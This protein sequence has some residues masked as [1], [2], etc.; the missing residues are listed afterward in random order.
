MERQGRKSFRTKFGLFH[1]RKLLWVVPFIHFSGLLI[2]FYGESVQRKT[3]SW[4][5][6]GCS[7]DGEGAAIKSCAFLE[8][9]LKLCA[10]V[11]G[12]KI[13]TWSITK[14]L[15]RWLITC[16]SRVEKCILPRTYANGP[17][18]ALATGWAGSLESVRRKKQSVFGWGNEMEMSNI[19]LFLLARHD[20][21]LTFQLVTALLSNLQ[22]ICYA[23]L[24]EHNLH[25]STICKHKR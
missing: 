19:S 22:N 23:F 18:S 9:S 24:V 14:V 4:W 6:V 5:L 8:T 7:I 1:P 13:K 2:F 10:M 21:N 25:N 15:S 3:S 20:S 11:R 17:S 12:L 16:L